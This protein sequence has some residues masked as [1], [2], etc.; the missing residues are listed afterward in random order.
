[1]KK[2]T[3]A[4]VFAA[5]LFCASGTFA[6]WK[7]EVCPVKENLNAIYFTDLNSGWTVGDK[8]TILRYASDNWSIFNSPTGNNLYS[9]A[10][11]SD[12]DG[13]IVGE[14]GCI[15]HY[16]GYHWELTQSPTGQDLYSVSFNETGNGMAVGAMGVVLQYDQHRWNQISEDYRIDLYSVALNNHRVWTGGYKEGIRVPIMKMETGYDA[17]SAE[18]F[19]VDLPVKSLSMPDAFNGWAVGSKNELLRF[20]GSSWERM[21]TSGQFAAL[22][23]V[24]FKD[25]YHGISAGYSGTILLYADGKWDKEATNTENRLNATFI[26]GNKYYVAGDKGTILAKTTSP[27][28]ESFKKSVFGAD[29]LSIFPNPGDQHVNLYLPPNRNSQEIRVSIRDVSGKEIKY[30]LFEKSVEEF[31]ILPTEDLKD[32]NYFI[33][34]D[35][36]TRSETRQLIIHHSK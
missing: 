35:A 3:F 8:G 34:I 29:E 25:E 32:G 11:L 31:N 28:T 16:N 36:G 9:V 1:M 7:Y 18:I 6:Q 10:M 33:T 30:M 14:K 26:I 15:L 13:W 22:R 21:K 19:T 5:G 27:V 4:L 12:K 17:G 2:N 24:F 20:N 23:S